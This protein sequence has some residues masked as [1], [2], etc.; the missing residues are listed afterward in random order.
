MKVIKYLVFLFISSY[1]LLTVA[2]NDSDVCPICYDKKVT[3]VL[4]CAHKMCSSCTARS[5]AVKRECP[6]CRYK[7]SSRECPL[8]IGAN[9]RENHRE[10]SR[11][12][13]LRSLGSLFRR[14]NHQVNSI[15]T[16]ESRARRPDLRENKEQELKIYFS[17]IARDNLREVRKIRSKYSIDVKNQDGNS[18]VHIA[19]KNGKVRMLRMLKKHQANFD[20]INNCGQ[21]PLHLAFKHKKYNAVDYLIRKDVNTNIRD[22]WGKRYDD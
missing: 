21:S 10:S 5:L 9:R 12:N 22:M 7:L 15:S 16:R 8:D 20:A 18:L 19:A 14:E 3:K 6:F 17:Y 13:N 1:T 11:V 2:S 4:P